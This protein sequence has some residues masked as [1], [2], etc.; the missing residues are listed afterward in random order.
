[1]QLPL[2]GVCVICCSYNDE[3]SCVRNDRSSWDIDMIDMVE[4][5]H[6]LSREDVVPPAERVLVFEQSFDLSRPL[7][8]TTAPVA[9]QR[10]PKPSSLRVYVFDVT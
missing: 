3:I 10:P 8:V 6:V 9:S 4:H 1:M 5:R 2:C 7:P